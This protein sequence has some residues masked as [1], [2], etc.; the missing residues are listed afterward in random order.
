MATRKKPVPRNKNAVTL[1]PSV[2]HLW[3]AA[4][5]MRVATRRESKT[6]MKHAVSRVEN[7]VADARHALR[8]AEAD[9]RGNIDGVRS[10]MQP[11]VVKFSNDVEARLAPV[12]AKLGLNTKAKRAPRKARK[13]AAKAPRRTARKPAKRTAKQAAN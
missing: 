7:T 8:R 11:K 3:L 4:L 9:L 6:A 13:T 10:Q 5:G 1:E 2:R 12:L